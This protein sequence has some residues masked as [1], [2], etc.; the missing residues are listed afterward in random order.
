MS[1]KLTEFEQALKKKYT[2][3]LE[4]ILFKEAQDIIDYC[5]FT[6]KDLSKFLIGPYLVCTAD[7]LSQDNF[8][9]NNT[10]DMMSNIIDLAS[11]KWC[12][13]TFDGEPEHPLRTGILASVPY[14]LVTSQYNQ[15]KYLKLLH[16]LDNLRAFL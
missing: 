7:C 1:I 8:S 6:Y 12:Y 5:R 9:F 10:V 14:V 4:L 16:Q 13:F 11:N 15:P 2:C 3:D